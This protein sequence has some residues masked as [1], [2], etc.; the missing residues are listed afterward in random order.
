MCPF[1]LVFHGP[2]KIRRFPMKIRRFHIR[3]RI[4]RFHI[5]DRVFFDLYSFLT[6]FLFVCTVHGTE[7]PGGLVSDATLEKNHTRVHVDHGKVARV[8]KI[9]APDAQVL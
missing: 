3:L 8:Q 7:T 5:Y 9:R 2:M 6:N 1:I 4:R